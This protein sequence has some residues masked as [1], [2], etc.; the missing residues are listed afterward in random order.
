M[1][2]IVRA[3]PGRPRRPS[4]AATYS[5]DRRVS[6]SGPVFHP[7]RPGD[8]APG[9]RTDRGASGYRHAGG[10]IP[11]RGRGDGRVRRAGRRRRRVVAHRRVERAGHP[12]RGG[13][14]WA[15]GRLGLAP[16]A[17]QVWWSD[18]T[19]RIVGLSPQSIRATR[20]RFMQAVHPDDRPELER[21]LREALDGTEPYRA[22]HRVVRPRL[23]RLRVACPRAG[24]A[25]RVLPEVLC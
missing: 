13:G 23:R 8:D 7:R 10:G 15:R 6:H 24:G 9:S 17:D 14:S 22:V 21:R 4:S 19:Y 1:I 11:A 20:E 5:S 2:S 25:G 16:L 3:S 18:E 12:R